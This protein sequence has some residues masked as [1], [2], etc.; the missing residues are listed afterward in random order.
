MSEPAGASRISRVRTRAAKLFYRIFAIGFFVRFFTSFDAV[1]RKMADVSLKIGKK[2][3][4]RYGRKKSLTARRAMACAMENNI[5]SFVFGRLVRLTCR[6]KTRLIGLLMLIPGFFSGAFFFLD[7]FLLHWGYTDWIS[8]VVGTVLT[9]A[10]MMLL[11]SEHS[12][13][14]DFYHSAFFRA[15]LA[16]AAGIS[17]DYLR[18]VPQNGAGHLYVILPVSFL[19]G[20]LG[21]LLRPLVLCFVVLE[22]LL[23]MLILSVPETGVLFFILL[24]PFA[25][26][27]PNGSFFLLA[28][29]ALSVIGYIGKL[30]RGNRAL[31]MDLQDFAVLLLTLMMVFSLF[32]L[33]EG[34]S[35]SGMLFTLCLTAAY[36]L[37][38][39][40]M[41]TTRWFIRCHAAF[42][43][44]A[45]AAA[46]AGVWQF[47]RAGGLSDFDGAFGYV[48]AG[49][50]GSVPFAY[51]MVLALAFS[52]PLLFEKRHGLSVCGAVSSFLFVFAAVLSGVQIA[53]FAMLLLAALYLSLLGMRGFGFSFLGCSALALCYLFLPRSVRGKV[54]AVLSNTAGRLPRVRAG[55]V[56]SRFFFSEGEGVSSRPSGFS[57]FIF[58]AGPGGIERMWPYFSGQ[59]AF[60][61]AGNSF[62][63]WFFCDYGL[64]GILILSAMLFVMI[65]NCFSVS[66]GAKGRGMPRF[67]RI[68]IGVVA[69]GVLFAFFENPFTDSFAVAAFFV[70]AAL[71]GAVLRYE[72]LRNQREQEQIYT[73]NASAELEYRVR[74][75]ISAKEVS[76]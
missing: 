23:V 52:L 29:L 71:I 38:S 43:V 37:I 41:Q 42:L 61:A 73:G 3:S 7:T 55:E 17:E 19:L 4:R 69:S 1:S 30:L 33:W 58:G 26:F 25:G 27:L 65:Q 47:F 67:A 28:F 40:V 39:N 60:E 68:G 2:K 14:Y 51:F 36:F 34:K 16:G 50:S 56:F 13:G 48:R 10:G 66:W 22:I 24:L 20:A 53:W 5:F 63:L 59:T 31:H 8:P 45:S 46:L 57:R 35:L 6:T 74:R 49:F 72:R 75:P 64:L 44:S 11:P 21:I 12:F 15:V 9:I 32:S 76:E 62:F 70:A 54:D 18:E